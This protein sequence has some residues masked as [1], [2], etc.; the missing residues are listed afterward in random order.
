MK[1][2]VVNRV[3]GAALAQPLLNGVLALALVGAGIYSFSRLPV[4]AYPDISPPTVEIISQWPGHAAEEV[5]RLITVPTE[6]GMNGA[7]NLR[8]MRSISLYGLSDV[9]LTFQDGTDNYFARQQ[10]FERI[11]DLSLPEGVSPGVSPLASPS[12]LVY[13]YM[14][15]SPDRSRDGAARTSRIGCSKGSTAPSPAS[16]T[17]RRSAARRCSTRCSSTRRGSPA[18]DS[19]SRR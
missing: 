5:E 15:Q 6:A 16:P 19:P 14:I 17:C 13:R 4:D 2:S 18:P 8:V 7:P 9:R 12:G 1:R 3:V 10:V 11:P